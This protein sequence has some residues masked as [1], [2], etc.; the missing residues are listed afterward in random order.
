MLVAGIIGVLGLF[1]SQAKDIGGAVTS[2]V[3]APQLLSGI[4]KATPIVSSLIF[5]PFVSTTYAQ[6]PSNDS[7]EIVTIV[8][9]TEHILELKS[10]DSK[11]SHFLKDTTIY[12][13]KKALLL[14]KIREIGK[15]YE[16]SS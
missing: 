10:V 1:I 4:A 16:W 8:E 7:I 9:G 2:G 12:Q 13:S 5:S 15:S 14:Q 6:E 11:K 3:A